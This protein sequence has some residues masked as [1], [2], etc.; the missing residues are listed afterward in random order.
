MKKPRWNAPLF[1]H[2]TAF[3]ASSPQSYHV[4]GHRNGSIFESVQLAAGQ[5]Q[6][7]Y[8]EAM[9]ALAQLDVTELSHTD[10]L[11]DPQGIIAEAQK[12]LAELYGAAHSFFLV[13]GSTAGNLALLLTLCDVGDLI[14]V[15]RNV[16]KSVINGCKLA[17]AKVVFLNPE[18]DADTALSVVPGLSTLQAA[19]EQY[20]QAKAVFLTNP[21]YYGLGA[22]LRPYVELTHQ[23]NMP[24]VVDEA[25]G[26]HYGIAAYS[27]SS[28]LAAGADAVVQS[29]HKTL[30]ALTMGAYL[31]IKGERINK[32]ELQQQL[33][34]LESSSPSY[35][36]MCSLDL[37]RAILEGCGKAWFE[38]SYELRAS[39]IEWLDQHSRFA[40]KQLAV[41]SRYYQD[42]YRLLLYDRRQ[43]WSG[44]YLQKSLESAG[45]WA[46][47]ATSQYVVLIWHMA[48]TREQLERLQRALAQL[49]PELAAEECQQPANGTMTHSLQQTII[50]QAA[51]DILAVSAPVD[52][53]RKMNAPTQWLALSEAIGCSCAEQ[54]VPYPPGIPVLFEGELITE[55]HVAGLLDYIQAG[56][57]FQGS[58]GLEREQIKVYRT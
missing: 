51:S 40:I 5:E 34:M 37:A 57:R 32:D 30:P 46:E 39:F 29:A 25:H 58:A 36:L 2:L 54:V 48:M 6:Q 11:H 55:Q 20:P 38:Q 17:G 15:Q 35:L 45:V 22:D 33:A 13:G 28:A 4:P 31:H 56:A 16:H 18:L 8:I 23:Y 26:A 12:L 9:A 42:P 24:L 19:M 49:E 50:Q 14:I 3:S 7:R 27:P 43:Q 21:N 52:L 44:Y 10:D 1:N 41:D 53:K 47:M